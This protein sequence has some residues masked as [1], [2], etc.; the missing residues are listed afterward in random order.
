[1]VREKT[2]IRTVA[3]GIFGQPMLDVTAW[4]GSECPEKFDKQAVRFLFLE[5][6]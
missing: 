4:S 5:Y 2:C 6:I 3:D 1:M